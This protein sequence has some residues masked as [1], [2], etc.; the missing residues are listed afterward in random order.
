M[1][2]LAPGKL[3]EQAVAGAW[4]GVLE[5]DCRDLGRAAD[6][7]RY[8]RAEPGDSTV[9]VIP[10]FIVSAHIDLR[11]SLMNVVHC[12]LIACTIRDCQVHGK[13]WGD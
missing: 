7:V 5:N 13:V 11:D 12:A 2:I 3:E 1:E 4:L 8:E 9:K 10:G 6:A